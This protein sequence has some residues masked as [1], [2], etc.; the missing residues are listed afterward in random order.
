LL[1]LHHYSTFDF[2]NSTVDLDSSLD[3]YAE[4]LALDPT[5]EMKYQ[6]RAQCTAASVRTLIA[7]CVGVEM[8]ESKPDAATQE[9][10][11]KLRQHHPC[12][13]QVM[14]EKVKSLLH[15]FRSRYEATLYAYTR[16]V[17]DPNYDASGNMAY[18]HEQSPHYFEDPHS[19]RVYHLDARSHHA[20]RNESQS[21]DQAIPERSNEC[22]GPNL[23][24]P[25]L[26]RTHHII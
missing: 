19:G 22:G 6:S 23:Q 5:L 9:E 17:E 14:V 12:T 26:N 20:C 2:E 13:P 25:Q 10:F 15:E 8:F 11:P 1:F 7:S 24:L 18:G 16:V 4:M 21:L 3:A